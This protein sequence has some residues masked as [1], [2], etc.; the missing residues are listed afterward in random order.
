MSRPLDFKLRPYPHF[1]QMVQ[2]GVICY[3][4]KYVSL[5]RS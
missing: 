2:L 3:N 5:E 1:P 4:R